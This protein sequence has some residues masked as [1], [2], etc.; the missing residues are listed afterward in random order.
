MKRFLGCISQRV[1]EKLLGCF[2]KIYVFF[3]S[4]DDGASEV[5]EDDGPPKIRLNI[6]VG[7]RHVE[8]YL[9]FWICNSS[10]IYV[11]CLTAGLKCLMKPSK[12]YNRAI[13]CN[14]NAYI[15][16]VYICMRPIHMSI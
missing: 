4:L 14:L 6:S 16:H 13:I 9:F 11:Y 2:L 3:V 7:E 10:H 5:S 15:V 12:L 1:M 8:F